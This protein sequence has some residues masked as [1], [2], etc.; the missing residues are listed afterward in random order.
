MN[1]EWEKMCNKIKIEK[2]KSIEYRYKKVSKK[3]KEKEKKKKKN[4]GGEGEE[5]K[6]RGKGGEREGKRR[7]KT[8][9]YRYYRCR[10]IAHVGYWSQSRLCDSHSCHK[11][12]PYATTR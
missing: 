12:T 11:R 3:I 10:I 1:T 9:W 5:G 2:N 7:K 6:E 4:E 8:V